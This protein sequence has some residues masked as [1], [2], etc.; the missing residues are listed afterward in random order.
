MG[1]PIPNM[2]IAMIEYLYDDQQFAGFSAWYLGG[3]LAV[4]VPW[5]AMRVAEREPGELPLALRPPVAR[6]DSPSV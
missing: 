5:T 2:P 6:R 3:N 4:T 1:P